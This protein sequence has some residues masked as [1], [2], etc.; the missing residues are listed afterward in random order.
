M[1]NQSPSSY[2]EGEIRIT[3]GWPEYTN[4][5]HHTGIDCACQDGQK[6]LAVFN[7][8]VKFISIGTPQSV[9]RV[10]MLDEDND[11]F[12]IYKHVYPHTELARNTLIGVG[13]YIGTPDLSG[14]AAGL[15][16]VYHLHIT[17]LDSD[18]A[19]SDPVQYLMMV[20]PDLKF[21]FSKN[22]YGLMEYYQ[23]KSYWDELKE[24]VVL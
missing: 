19:E 18:G 21:S 14:K 3:Q 5:K 4:G 13:Q 9:G 11:C 2:K 10:E 15:C 8:V 6:M 23:K 16:D 7:G 12:V 24:R 20:Q 17:I 22:Y 1:K